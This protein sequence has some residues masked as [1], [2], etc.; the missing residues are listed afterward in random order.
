MIRL[1]REKVAFNKNWTKTFPSCALKKHRCSASGAP[2]LLGF[3]AADTVQWM[4]LCRGT[5]VHVGQMTGH[6]KKGEK[7][8]D[9]D[10][11]SILLTGKD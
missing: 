6:L 10:A 4:A 5:A 8:K 1:H 9:G 3:C 11:S 7:R 2:I